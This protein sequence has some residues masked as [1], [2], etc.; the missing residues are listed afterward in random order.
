M[1][2]MR[3]PPRPSRSVLMIGMP[4]ATAASNDSVVLFFSASC[5]S[6]TP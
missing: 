2:L 1:R 6:A 5:A 3:L 4:P